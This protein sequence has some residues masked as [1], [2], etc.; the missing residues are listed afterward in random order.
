MF[1]LVILSIL[2]SAGMYMFKKRDGILNFISEVKNRK[3]GLLPIQ[4]NND[5]Y[6]STLFLFIATVFIWVMFFY[7]YNA[8]ELEVKLDEDNKKK[9]STFCEN[10]K[11]IIQSLDTKPDYDKCIIDGD[12]TKCPDTHDI[13]ETNN[14]LCKNKTDA[15]KLCSLDGYKYDTS[16]II[17]D[18]K[19]L[20]ENIT[21]RHPY[22][23][24]TKTGRTM[25]WVFI[26]L[27][28]LSLISVC[29]LLFMKFRKSGQSP[30]L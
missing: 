23:K 30:D 22:E 10:Q 17:K 29:V 15:S 7:N 3:F 16:S 4:S 2:I 6:I 12:N 13:Y 9:I 19:K 27:V 24:I 11:N 14:K 26:I 1:G 25:G 8:E 28:L 20:Y 5:F 21:I 18:C